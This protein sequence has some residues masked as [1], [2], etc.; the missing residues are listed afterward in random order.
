M[1]QRVHG[2]VDV[3]GERKPSYEALRAEASPIEVFEAGGR[4]GELKIL[5]KA[6]GA[7]PSY[8][9]RGYRLR[10]VVY[11]FGEI[12]V[13]RVET[14]LPDLG[15]GEQASL[16]VKFAETRPVQVKLDALRPT[17]DSAR[18]LVWRP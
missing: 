9:L 10:A 7:A 14:A 6:R 18:S 4:P 8:G 1:R 16:T 5:V 3:Y 11:G 12:P 15:P 13:E 17:G 2:V